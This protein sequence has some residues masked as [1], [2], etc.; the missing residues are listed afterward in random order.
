MGIIGRKTV[1]GAVLVGLGAAACVLP[2]AA[3]RAQDTPSSPA[4]PASPAD[5]KAKPLRKAKPKAPKKAVPRDKAAQ[6]VV[7]PPPVVLPDPP[8]PVVQVRQ[9]GLTQCAG[10]VDQM[11]H[12]ILTSNYNIQSGWN[13][14]APTEHVFQ[15]VAI[16]NNPQNTPPDGMAALVAT[17][18]PNGA[19]D[20]VALQVFPLA[21]DCDT[22]QKLIQAEGSVATPI[23]N[24]RILFDRNGRRL[25]LVPGFAKTCIAIAVDSTFG[26]PGK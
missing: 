5:N 8:T 26:V 11:A 22:A 17:P 20:G 10:V 24:A 19:C 16:L 7:A 6:P 2:W 12:Q 4:A 14:A 15:S 25:F 13:R 23:L 18:T 3:A 9:I 21:G 1:M